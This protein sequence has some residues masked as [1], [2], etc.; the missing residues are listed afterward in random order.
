MPLVPFLA[1]FDILAGVSV[2]AFIYGHCFC[3]FFIKK[4]LHIHETTNKVKP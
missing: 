2:S 3:H 1:S 4:S